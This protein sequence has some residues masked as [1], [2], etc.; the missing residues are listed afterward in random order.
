MQYWVAA[1]AG[2]ALPEP[3][4]GVT[5]VRVPEGHS[6]DALRRVIL[7][8]FD[9]SLGNGLGPLADKVFRI[10][11]LGHLSALQLVGVIGGVEMGLRA[12]GIPHREGG[13][14]AAMGYLGGN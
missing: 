1:R 9:L 13:V 14:Q 11:H 5:T 2:Q 12:A 4:A 7:E 3:E 8:K 10:A 6:A